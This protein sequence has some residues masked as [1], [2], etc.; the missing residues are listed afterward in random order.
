MKLWHG[1]NCQCESCQRRRASNAQQ[2]EQ[3]G[4]TLHFPAMGIGVLDGQVSTVANRLLGP[5]ADAQAEI[6]EPTRHHRVRGPWIRP[7]SSALQV[8]P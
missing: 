6:S 1:L 5:L 8:W 7:F 4:R 3:H 2:Y